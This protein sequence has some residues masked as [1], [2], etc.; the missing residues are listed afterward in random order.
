M[1]N[2]KRVLLIDDEK[3]LCALTK[4][5]LEKISNYTVATATSG[6]EGLQ[7][8]KEDKPDLI[9]LDIIMPGMNGFEVL[10]ELK[11]DISLA[12]VPVIILSGKSDEASRVKA[13]EL[14]NEMF[15]IKPVTAQE[16][17]TKIDEIFKIRMRG[18]NL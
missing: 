2:R 9:V 6:Q 15:L 13:L 10:E 12:A 3:D 8:A 16:L 18:N 1:G 11:K 7:L 5:L 4:K 14:Y 17:K